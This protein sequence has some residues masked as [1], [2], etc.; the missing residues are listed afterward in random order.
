MNM[1]LELAANRNHELL[2]HHSVILDF[3]LFIFSFVDGNKS[4]K[5]LQI[6]NSVEYGTFTSN[7]E[8]I[9]IYDISYDCGMFPQ[10]NYYRYVSG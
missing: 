3:T 7:S 6:N 9:Y 8:Y 1:V 2:Y 10:I 5:C 4:L